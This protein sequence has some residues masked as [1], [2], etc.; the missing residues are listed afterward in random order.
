MKEN[1]SHEKGVQKKKRKRLKGIEMPVNFHFFLL[2]SKWMQILSLWEDGKWIFQ[3]RL[4]I[5]VYYFNIFYTGWPAKH[6]SIFLVPCKQWHVQCTLLFTCTLDNSLLPM[7]EKHTA[8]FNWSPCIS[9]NGKL[10]GTNTPLTLSCIL[11]F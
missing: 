8:M 11:L 7:Y 3:W 10:V 1:D 2:N 5:D 9:C 4:P 6:C